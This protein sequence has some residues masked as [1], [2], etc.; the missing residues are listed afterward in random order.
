MLLFVRSDGKREQTSGKVTIQFPRSVLDNSIDTL[1][2]N[3][4][5]SHTSPQW[6]W[7]SHSLHLRETP[8]AGWTGWGC[9]LEELCKSVNVQTLFCEKGHYF[10]TCCVHTHTH[11]HT[12]SSQYISLSVCVCVYVCVCMCVCVCVCVCV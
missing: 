5:V 1:L 6:V 7:L 12:H 9:G 4:P 8:E 11:T 10:V 2:R 3:Q